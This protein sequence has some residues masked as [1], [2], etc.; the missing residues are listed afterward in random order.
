MRKV[1]CRTF[2]S[3][4]T[5]FLTLCRVCLWI[6]S[7]PPF[8]LVVD[9]EPLLDEHSALSRSTETRHLVDDL[10]LEYQKGQCGYSH[11]GVR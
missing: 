4:G 3:C 9:I 11:I 8:S 10:Q 2:N 7:S 1:H 6:S 5:P